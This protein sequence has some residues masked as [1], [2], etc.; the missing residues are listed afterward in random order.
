MADFCELVAAYSGRGYLAQ[1]QATRLF[2][3]P[4]E[5]LVS[6]E[7]LSDLVEMQSRDPL[8]F[9]RLLDGEPS[10]FWGYPV[11]TGSVT[12]CLHIQ[13]PLQEAA[14]GARGCHIFEPQGIMS[15]HGLQA[16]AMLGTADP[17]LHV[18]KPLA[19]FFDLCFLVITYPSG[20]SKPCRNAI[21][22]TQ[23]PRT[24]FQ[25]MILLPPGESAAMVSRHT[26]E[27]HC[28]HWK[29]TSKDVLCSDPVEYATL[30]NLLDGRKA[31]LR[32]RAALVKGSSAHIRSAPLSRSSQGELLQTGQHS[33]KS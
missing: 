24:I 7:I 26:S 1:R 14:V 5:I 31:S 8:E 22:L 25:L 29:R 27:L 11:S 9:V 23:A 30:K 17:P 6:D 2:R 21:S 16:R 32:R 18:R 10:S 15:R 12:S 13:F 20:S 28:S 4:W 19:P 3:T 33:A